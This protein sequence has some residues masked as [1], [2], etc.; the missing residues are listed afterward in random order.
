M[1]E[2]K[3]LHSPIISNQNNKSGSQLFHCDYDDDQIVKVFLN[4]FDVDKNT[5][6]L[7]ALSADKSA[8]LLKKIKIKFREH[9][10]HI[11]NYITN[12]EIRSFIGKRGDLTLIDTSSCF[13][14]GSYGTKKDRLILYANFVSR[15]SYRFTPIFKNVKD[16]NINKLHSPLSKLSYLVSSREK[17][18]YLN[19]K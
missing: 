17:K 11:E 9:T 14:R 5:G 10:D 19:N 13:H 1:V 16:Q 7:E 8:F 4:I 12:D 15:N 18:F 6:P 3:L 2:L